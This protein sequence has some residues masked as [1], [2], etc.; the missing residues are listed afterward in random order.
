VSHRESFLAGLVSFYLGRLCVILAAALTVAAVL[1]PAAAFAQ[2]R[3]VENRNALPLTKFYDTPRPLPGGKPGELIR[4]QSF[5]EYE[6]PISVSAIRI[7][8]HSRSAVGE[9]V[10]ASGVVLFPYGK[11]P[12]AGGWPVIVWAHG[13]TG[14]AR[15]CA[16][17]LTRN[18]GHGPFLSM[19]VNLGYAVVAPDYTGLGT[20]FRNAFLDSPSN[21][22]DLIA[23]VPAARAAE[24]SL[25]GRWIAIGEAEGSL[26][27]VAVAEK[28]HETRDPG[29][30]GSIAISGLADPQEIYQP[31]GAGSSSLKLATLAYGIKTVYPE[32]QIADMLTEKGLGVYHRIEQTCSNAGAAPDFSPSET[33][34]PGWEGNPFVR[35]YF[36]RSHLAETPASRPILVITSDADSAIPGATTAQAIARMCKQGDQIQSQLYPADAG[37]LI[38]DSVRDQIAWIEAR[39]SGRPSTTTCP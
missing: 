21:A 31:G 29:Y 2:V 30:L 8:Y 3:P 26:A 15:R 13:T 16:P 7:L 27:A 18:I 20:D 32:F 4:S 9:D 33:L 12:P 22:A 6:L 23:A 37:S 39:F 17:S 28:Q 38:G 1:A 10:A 36:L 14:V 5:E 19:Y 35:R 34:K 25:G 11:K 24:P